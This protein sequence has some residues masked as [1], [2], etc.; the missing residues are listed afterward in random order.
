MNILVSGKSL[1]SDW[2]PTRDKILTAFKDGKPKAHREVA[3]ATGLSLPAVWR[4]L[5]DYW[6][7][8]FLLRTEK[9]IFEAVRVF[10]CRAGFTRNTRSYYL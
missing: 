2:H 4:A 7:E 6:K 3:K 8:G 1:M 9:P 10:K 5:H